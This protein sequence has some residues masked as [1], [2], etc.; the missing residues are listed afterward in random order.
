M[1]AKVEILAW[2]EPLSSSGLYSDML[3][4]MLNLLYAEMVYLHGYDKGMEMADRIA[5]N[6]LASVN[7]HTKGGE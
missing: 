2:T 7:K 3:T 1:T 6:L 5:D 4:G